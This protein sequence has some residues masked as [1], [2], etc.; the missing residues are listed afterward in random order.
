M[1]L[2][3]S[4]TFGGSPFLGFL[5]NKLSQLLFLP[6]DFKSFSLSMAFFADNLVG[7]SAYVFS[8]RILS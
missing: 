6:G 7:V 4:K 8:L 5:V 1:S 2:F 3:F